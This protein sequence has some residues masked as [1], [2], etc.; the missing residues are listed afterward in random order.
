MLTLIRKVLPD[1]KI[2]TEKQFMINEL[3]EMAKEKVILFDKKLNNY[4]NANTDTLSNDTLQ[5]DI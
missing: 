1:N 5:I 4:L 2:I 3:I